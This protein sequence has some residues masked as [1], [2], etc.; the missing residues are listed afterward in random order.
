MSDPTVPAS[1]GEKPRLYL[2]DGYSN[3]FRAYYA[4]RGLSSSRGEPTNAV[5]GFLQMLRK[6][7][8]D[9]DPEY[10]GVAFDVSSATVRKEKF[11]GY[12]AQR[13]PMPED[14]R[15]QIPW[16]RQLLEAFRI[17]ILE[18][19]KYEADDVIGTLSH[20]AVAAGFEV[21]VVSPDKDLMQLVTD[22]VSVHHT[23]RDKRYDPAGVEEDYGVSPSRI[24]DLLALMG[25]SSDNVPGVPGIGEKGAQK[26]IAEFG[27]LESLLDRASEVQ[28]K[29]YREGLLNH[30]AEA[31]LSKELVTIHTDLDLELQPESLVREEPDWETLLELCW[32]FDFRQV[33]Q[34]LEQDHGAASKPVASARELTTVEELRAALAGLEGRIPVAVVGPAD[35]EP[36]GLAVAVPTSEDEDGEDEEIRAVFIDFRRS[37][38][39]DEVV[40]L[41]RGW[42]AD[43]E[44]RLIGHDVKEV[45]RLL[46]PRADVRC[47][48]ADTM[49]MSYV[50]RSA[51]RNHD[52]ATV[53]MDRLHRTPIDPKEAGFEKNEAPMVGDDRLT[54]LA[55]ERVLL[56]WQ[57]LPGLLTELETQELSAVYDKLEEPLVEV[58]A[59]LE[60]TGVLLD[61]DFLAKMSEELAVE[62]EAVEEELYELAGERINLNSPHQLGEVMFEKLGYPTGK[63]TSKTRRWSTNAE[64][65]EDL[66]AQGYEMAGG[67][68]KYRELTKLKSTY[69]DALP[70]MVDDEGRVHTR[71]NQAVAATGRLSSAH[72]NLQNIP[73]RTEL[74]QR[75]RRAF[76]A[77]EGYRLVVADYS[78]IELRV[79][80]HVAEEETMIE[81]FDRGEDIHAATAAI[82]FGGSPLLINAEQRRMAKVI[83][84]GI[85]YGMTSWGLAQNLGIGK[86]DAQRFIDTYMERYPGVRQ[87]TEQTLEEA[88]ETGQVRTMYGRVR[89]LPD[90]K[91]R[92]WNLRE[93]AKRMAINAPI[94][95]TAA[96]LLKLA[97]IAV[98]G[99]LRRDLPQ[100]RFLLTVHDELVLECPDRQVDELR[101]LVREEMEGVAELKVPLVVEVGSG[102]TWYD[103]KD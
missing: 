37:K 34:E 59:T 7:L 67:V 38:L 51:L 72:P 99:R 92:N 91:S 11:E 66:A 42:A 82:V 64:T 2:I 48:L 73:I 25:D 94:Q 68:L 41:L 5:F 49:L 75:I 101:G 12:K 88:N 70:E 87:Y 56:P 58:L 23:G 43:P 27:D 55:G 98:D 40:D 63:K 74:G 102:P 54:A 29:S 96:D 84:F 22:G 32:R 13:K 45:L 21:I 33:A 47:S 78:Q 39:R 89:Q 3:I 97:M 80:A 53:V 52:F 95:G 44:V 76:R 83:N 71:F 35:D 81:A 19:E 57:M 77:S 65:L 24:V 85:I 30:R 15:P 8:R 79:L 1:G 36:M 17:P 6:L 28:R 103:A 26:L 100:A 9:E 62:I 61:V 10:V 93:G 69:V 18:M 14:L 16:V 46:G 60:E 90:I 4:I 50:V 31:E 86:S 20:K